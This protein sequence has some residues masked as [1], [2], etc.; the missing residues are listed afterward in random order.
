LFDKPADYLAFEK[1]LHEAHERAGIR[2]LSEVMRWITV[3]HAQRWHAHLQTS[4]SGPVYQG[5]FKSFPVQAD[6]HFLNFSD[7]VGPAFF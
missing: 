4:G 1:I 2:E 7:E 6:E 3:T 5:R